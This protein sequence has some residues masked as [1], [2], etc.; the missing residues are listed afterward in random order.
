[1]KEEKRREKTIHEFDL[2]PLQQNVQG[3]SFERI[4]HFQMGSGYMHMALTHFQTNNQIPEIMQ[5]IILI[6]QSRE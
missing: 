3:N 6:H 5:Q 4:L 1:M 2:S